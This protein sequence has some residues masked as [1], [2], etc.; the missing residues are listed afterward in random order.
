MQPPTTPI[1]DCLSYSPINK[2][3]SIVETVFFIQFNKPF[4]DS[5]KSKLIAIG[6]DLK[7]Q[8]PKSNL[9]NKTAFKFDMSALNNSSVNEI[10]VVG[11]ELQKTNDDGSLSWMLRIAEDIISVHC[12]DYTRWDD[13]WEKAK[14]YL[15]KSREHIGGRDN[16]ISCIGL[17]YI[18]RFCYNGKPN[19][20]NLKE[21]FKSNTHYISQTAF[22]NGPLWHCNSGWFE[23]PNDDIKY[24][25]QLN[26][27]ADYLSIDGDNKTLSITIDHNISAIVE[28]H[29]DNKHQ[30]LT[31][32]M[33]NLH[34][35]NKQLLALL[36]TDKITNQINLS[37]PK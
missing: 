1:K 17:R 20:S 37:L 31:S 4:S 36:L 18:D 24:L 25:N 10:E 19:E 22:D 2:A 9:I 23:K 30:D 34:D 3:H 12:L 28:Q 5:T 15:N 27:S 32:F 14:Y 26:V 8:L 29:D 6:D 13:V 16:F 7:D 21:L 11:I 33:N 35:K